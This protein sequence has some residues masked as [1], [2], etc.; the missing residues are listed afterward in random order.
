MGEQKPEKTKKHICAGLLAHVDAGKTTLSEDILYHT[1]VIRKAGRVDHRDTFFDT[2][3]RERKRGITIF[4][5]E[6]VFRLGDTEF[7]LMD[8]P[9]HTD[10]SA[11]MER[12]LSV[13]DYAVLIISGPDGVQSHTRTLWRLLKR[14]EL[15][16]FIFINKMDM[17]GT[18]KADIM[19]ELCSELSEACVVF[20]EGFI[21][22]YDAADAKGA[23][24]KAEEPFAAVSEEE[25]EAIAMS[26][27]ALME[28][29]LERGGIQGSSIAK[30]IKK[31][32]LYPCIF[33][34]AL[35]DEGVEALLKA[36]DIFTSKIE[37]GTEFSAR[38]YKITR[39]QK[40]NR[41]THMKLMGGCIRIKDSIAISKVSGNGMQA[42]ARS[43]GGNASGAVRDS[44]EDKINTASASDSPDIV[45][46]KIEGIRQYSGERYTELT[47]AFAGMVVA[48]AGLK[49]TYAGMGLGALRQEEKPVLVPLFEYALIPP[50]DV[51]RKQLYL[52]LKPL[53]DELPE[54]L[55]S[56]LPEQD[57][58][59]VRL[60]GDV[61]N[62]VLRDLV[63]ERF[64]VNVEFS[65]VSVIY[66]E[67]IASKV[68][69]VGHFEPLR[70]YAEVH[71]LLE[72]GEPGSGIEAVDL[73]GEG[74]GLSRNYRRL[75]LSHILEREHVG[76]LTGA[77]LTD[78]RISLVAGRSHDKHTEGGDF[79]EATY[80]AIRQGLMYA[81]NVLLE[82]YYDYKIWLPTEY[83]GRAITDIQQ[84]SGSFD[85]DTLS[86][87]ESLIRGRAPV[88]LMKNYNGELISYTK[89]LGRLAL[90]FCGYGPCHDADEAVM[91]SGYDPE[92]D[93]D[94]PTG[95]VFCAHGAG[96][97]V[98]WNEVY[99]MMHLPFATDVMR[100]HQIPSGKSPQGQLFKAGI[101]GISSGHDMEDGSFKEEGSKGIGPGEASDRGKRTGDLSYL[102]KGYEDDK[103]LMGIF[104]RTFGLTKSER[105][106]DKE[107]DRGLFKSQAKGGRKKWSKNG[108]GADIKADPRE[109][110]APDFV[111]IEDRKK[112]YLLVDGYNII[113][114]WDELKELSKLNLDSARLLLMD[115]LSNYQ[116]YK[117]M[118]LILVFDAYRV[119][120]GQRKIERYHNIY[121]VYTEEAETADKYI[122]KTVHDMD[123]KHDVTVATSD[124]LEQIIVFGEGA[125]R[126][127]ARE[128]YEE[129]MAASEDM[130]DQFLE[131]R[132]KLW[133]T[134]LKEN[135]TS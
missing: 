86:D 26:S 134:V 96:Y 130:R 15:P 62:E 41:L 109:A 56:Y 76:V 135:E 31:R 61:Q 34:S 124:G 118:N 49:G 73:M 110:T 87:R 37:Y 30:A 32:R 111:R 63:A 74:K 83:V 53:E 9:G 47:E 129:V 123:K 44:F 2:D 48:V 1:G 93:I 57:E 24:D 115:I 12:V 45:S 122:E 3:S 89:G 68:E 79:R 17:E 77:G 14:Y 84:R 120:G 8:T 35:K 27:E 59:H 4:S 58:I 72:P 95:S 10:F 106:A 67:T 85:I 91:A 101:A 29:Y 80:R 46:E 22:A 103:E 66:K 105:Y 70:H 43:E 6:A 78:V 23:G 51:D 40:G 94:D 121:V 112:S 7:N 104:R 65:E 98:P 64:S 69:G 133:N 42:S 60:M 128:L 18:D 52:K 75:I 117:G 13:L 50:F 97:Y 100:Q 21:R 16:T 33:G 28:E 55:I 25:L 127:S 38:V 11:E 126:L 92:S 39:D 125:A 5:K 116:G 36:L 71:L 82:P 20:D 114:A 54:L 108:K 90:S 102:S 88:S 19:R 131:R 113:F 132:T 119:K 99:G 81:E 107:D